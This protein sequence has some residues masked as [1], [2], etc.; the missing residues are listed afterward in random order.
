MMVVAKK[1]RV[2]QDE[3][4]AAYERNGGNIRATAAEIGISRSSV[5]R[6]LAPLGKL[7]KPIAAGSE[8]GTKTVKF[9]LPPKGEVARYILTSAQNN[10]RVHDSAWENLLALAEYYDAQ[11]I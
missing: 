11:I 7:D 4:L 2:P 1:D 5:R 9:K 10:T 6:K 3:V 8:E